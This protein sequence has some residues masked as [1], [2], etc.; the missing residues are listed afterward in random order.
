MLNL[1]KI[2]VITWWKSL[3]RGQP[4]HPQNP[5]KKSIKLSKKD[6][7]KIQC[8]EIKAHIKCSNNVPMCFNK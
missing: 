5:F 1:L 3:I 4:Y 6:M 8:K 2:I 7:S